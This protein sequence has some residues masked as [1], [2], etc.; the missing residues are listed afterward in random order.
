LEILYF[1]AAAIVLYLVSDWVLRRIEQARGRPLAHRSAIFFVILLV[2]AVVVF[3]IIRYL[4][5]G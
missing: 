3:R 4:A 2:L 1:T 5:G